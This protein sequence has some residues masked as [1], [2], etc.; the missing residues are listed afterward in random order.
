ME[1]SKSPSPIPSPKEKILMV[2]FSI[3]RSE[4]NTLEDIIKAIDISGVG[5]IAVVNENDFWNVIE[6][7]R[8]KGAEGILVVPIEK[9]VL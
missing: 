4:L 6:Q 9:M 7:L 2:N 8:D 3:Q 5:F 1:P